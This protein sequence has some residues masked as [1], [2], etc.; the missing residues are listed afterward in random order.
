M[1]TF[2]HKLDEYLTSGETVAVATIT[3]VQRQRAA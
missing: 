1:E 3:E 2:Y